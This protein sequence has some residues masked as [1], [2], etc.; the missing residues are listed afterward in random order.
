MKHYLH[1]CSFQTLEIPLPAP[2]NL[3]SPFGITILTLLTDSNKFKRCVVYWPS[4]SWGSGTSQFSLLSWQDLTWDTN[5]WIPNCSSYLSSSTWT[6]ITDEYLSSSEGLKKGFTIVNQFRK[7]SEVHWRGF[8]M[9][10][11]SPTPINP[12]KHCSVPS[13][14][15]INSINILSSFV[16]SWP[17][18]SNTS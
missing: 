11:S 6:H 17:W 10:I 2:N 5:S 16:S 1:V 13:P 15:C 3:V 14:T 4:L 8:N 12:L 18:S 9:Q 7:H